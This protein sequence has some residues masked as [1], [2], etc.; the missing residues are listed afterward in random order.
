MPPI[1]KSASGHSPLPSQIVIIPT[2]FAPVT[3]ST[4]GDVPAFSR[5]FTP[6]GTYLGFE[7]YSPLWLGPHAFSPRF[8]FP[9]RCQKQDINLHFLF[10]GYVPAN[11]T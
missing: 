4:F 3:S 1:R 6:P 9:Y 10:A 7:G 11:E 2:A 5:L 8:R